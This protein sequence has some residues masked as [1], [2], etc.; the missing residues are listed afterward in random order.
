MTQTTQTTPAAP[1]K[2]RSGE[3]GARVKGHAVAAGDII[4]IITKSGKSWDAQI[5]KVIWSG[6]G[7]S[8]C[9][10]ESLDRGPR[11]SSSHRH[12]SVECCGYPCPV[13]GHRCTPAHP[14]HDCL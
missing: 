3:W 12:S 6:K 10:T 4:H 14:C 13:D 5:T 9:A 11:R 2:L 8:L 1:A 7:V